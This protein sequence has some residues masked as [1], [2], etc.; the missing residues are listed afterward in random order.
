[1]LKFQKGCQ[2][3]PFFFFLIKLLINWW[4]FPWTNDSYCSPATGLSK[5]HLF[6]SL[7]T[8]FCHTAPDVMSMK[9]PPPPTWLH[10]DHHY[11]PPNKILRGGQ[12]FSSNFRLYWLSRMS[13]GM[14]FH[15]THLNTLHPWL[16]FSISVAQLL[17]QWDKEKKQ[18]RRWCQ[19]ICCDPISRTERSSLKYTLLENV[20][21]RCYSKAEE[22][23]EL[24]QRKAA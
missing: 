12:D 16:P 14:L 24:S 5:D 22:Q 3:L 8:L 20:G 11:K 9:A 18:R 4:P 7:N 2:F 17:H 1:M 13:N 15:P 21:T 10:Q 6:R 23:A 19:R